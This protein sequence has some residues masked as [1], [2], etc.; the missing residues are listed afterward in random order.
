ME[1]WVKYRGLQDEVWTHY[2]ETCPPVATW[3]S[4]RL[5]LSMAA[6]HGWYTMQIDYVFALPQAP[7]ERDLYMEVP[8]GFKVDV[9]EDGEYVLQ[10]LR[11]VYGQKQAS[12]V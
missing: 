7:V 11:N 10:L 9:A 5:L 6:I 1:G 8:K 12:T 2:D 3:N 4:I